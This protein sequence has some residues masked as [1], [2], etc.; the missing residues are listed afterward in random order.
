MR[1]N[2]SEPQVET[3]KNKALQFS[4]A[5]DNDYDGDDIHGGEIAS[6]LKII[7]LFKERN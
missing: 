1:Q 2:P 5:Q 7:G 3:D 6:H 4:P